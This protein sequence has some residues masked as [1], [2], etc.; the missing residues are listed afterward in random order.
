MNLWPA[1]ALWS[2]RVV[3][4]TMRETFIPLKAGARVEASF[5]RTEAN[6]S[7]R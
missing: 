3:C 4:T 2:S 7:R 5:G 1:F 6:E